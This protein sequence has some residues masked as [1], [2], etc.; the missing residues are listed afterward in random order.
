[1]YVRIVT[2]YDDESGP[3]ASIR[4]HRHRRDLSSPADAVPQYYLRVYEEDDPK[5]RRLSDDV[6][7]GRPHSA[8]RTTKYIIVH[9][10]SSRDY[11]TVRILMFIQMFTYAYDQRNPYALEMTT[12]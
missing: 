10:R 6:P 5:M 1:M 3:T 4:L 7:M 2:G 8:M 12:V 11:F 9:S